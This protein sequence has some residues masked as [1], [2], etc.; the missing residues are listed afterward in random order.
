[1]LEAEARARALAELHR[2]DLD[3]QLNQL[4]Q[5]QFVEQQMNELR[6]KQNGSQSTR[7]AKKTRSSGENRQVL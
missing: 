1:M 4:T 7:D 3:T 2:N 6:A 5:E